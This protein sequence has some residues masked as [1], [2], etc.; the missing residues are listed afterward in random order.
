MLCTVA[1]PV[2]SLLGSV[3]ALVLPLSNPSLKYVVVVVPVPPSATDC[4]LSDALSV[5]VKL[6]L[7]APF[8]PGVK[9]TLM[10]QE[11]PAASVLLPLG[12]VFV[13]AKSDAFVPLMVILLI[14]NGVVPLLVSVTACAALA[15]PTF[16]LPKLT[17]VGLRLTAGAVAAPVPLRATDC[18][19]LFAVSLKTSVALRAP[20]STRGE[21]HIDGAGATRRQC[22]ATAGA[23]VGLREVRRIR[24]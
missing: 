19:L 2:L 20:M 11:L 1:L 21:G 12:Q 8:A 18:G 16:W 5:K 3:H 15:D 6:A 17:L 7:R 22:A 10:V 14:L 4:G 23:G 24:S 9:V 13:C